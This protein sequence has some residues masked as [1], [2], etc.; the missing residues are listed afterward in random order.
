MKK[1][2][3][4]SKVKEEG[5]FNFK[6]R[7]RNLRQYQCKDCTRKLIKSHYYRNKNY[8]LSKAKRRNT[9]FKL[10]IHGYLRSYLLNHPC[11][12][13]GE[14]DLAVL[15]F[16]HKGDTDKFKAV[17]QM[18]RIQYPFEKILE[19]VDKCDVRCANC[20]RRKTAEQFKWYK[21]KMPL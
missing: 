6:V 3:R 10:K 19:E 1:C 18:M 17:S 2:S 12:D 20:H 9:E 13:C 5:E 11:I 7:S 8:Y 16:D 21:L 15:E 4:C 14:T